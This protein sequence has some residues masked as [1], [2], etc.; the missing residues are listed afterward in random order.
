[1]R[2]DHSKHSKKIFA[3]VKVYNK[4]VNDWV[5]TSVA[6]IGDIKQSAYSDDHDGWLVC[7]GRS[8]SRSV[9]SELFSIIGTSFGN[10]DG[11]TFKLPDTRGRVLGSIGTG[12]GL[13]ARTLGASVGAETHTLTTS[14]MPSHTHGN[15]SVSGSLGLMTSNGA[16]TASAGLDTT[17]GE[18]NLYASPV[19]ITINSAGG[20]GAHNNM[21]PTLFIGKTFIFAKYRDREEPQVGNDIYDN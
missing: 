15:N 19:A 12:A 4:V 17:V 1:M 2:E 8:L 3:S 6:Q 18:P 7:D 11:N 20:G 13:T 9:Y 5:Q 14:E 16:N 10:D 21:Q